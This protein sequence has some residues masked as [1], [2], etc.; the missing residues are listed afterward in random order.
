MGLAR[1]VFDFI[2]CYRYIV[3]NGT[4]YYFLFD[5]NFSA[6]THS[7][8][9]E[10]NGNLTSVVIEVIDATGKTI[11][12]EMVLS[13]LTAISTADWAQGMYV[14]KINQNNSTVNK[15]VVKY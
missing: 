10:G 14:V 15:K 3:P 8:D 13:E 2:I 7:K 5:C 12:K 6:D 4:S 11:Y 9:R 1:I